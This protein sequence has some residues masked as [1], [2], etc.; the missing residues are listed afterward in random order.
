M[1]LVLV[2]SL[3]APYVALN[4]VAGPKS[5]RA[6]T[7]ERPCCAVAC[8]ALEQESRKTK[9]KTKTYGWCGSCGSSHHPVLPPQM[10]QIHQ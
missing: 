2:G 7:H 8:G 5:D 10:R 3:L 4:R 9:T 1:I 6:L